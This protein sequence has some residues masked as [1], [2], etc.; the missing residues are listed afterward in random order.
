MWEIIF[1]SR[2]P[3]RRM[4]R[5]CRQSEH[6]E[7]PRCSAGMRFCRSRRPNQQRSNASEERGSDS[8]NAQLVREH[9]G[10][11]EA[12]PLGG[13]GEAHPVLPKVHV[14]KNLVAPVLPQLE[15]M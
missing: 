7:G 15:Q 10:R 9:A 4:R 8:G 5:M 12:E 2:N 6:R 1:S 13:I 3:M 11:Q 14:G